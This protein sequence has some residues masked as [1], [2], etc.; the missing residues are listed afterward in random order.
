MQETMSDERNIL[1]GA[2]WKSDYRAAIIY[3][4]RE[5]ERS[6]APMHDRK[7]LLGE[8]AVQIYCIADPRAK[9]EQTI[10]PWQARPTPHIQI[11]QFE[12]L[13]EP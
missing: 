13:V 7:R 12:L 5:L 8:L 9:V 3:L 11:N 10:E 6:T 1:E 4:M 2:E